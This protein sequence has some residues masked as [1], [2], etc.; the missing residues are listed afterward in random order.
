MKK[1]L[2]SLSK[3]ISYI[4]RHAPSD[5]KLEMDQEGWVSIQDLLQV[6]RKE[7]D[8]W[9]TL[10]I[11]DLVEIINHSPKQRFELINDKIRALYGHSLDEK[12]KKHK[13]EP[14]EILYHGTTPQVAELVSKEGLK[15]MKRQFIHLSINEEIAMEVGYR[16]S[17]T[18]VILSIEARKAYHDG[19]KF[20]VGNDHVWLADFIPSKYL[21]IKK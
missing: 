21:D 13:V 15:P 17:S 9:Q 4:L 1:S 11:S 14:P 12:L 2:A 5:Y 20:Y 10:T 19:V 16:K 6:L 18:P 3:K 7:K 8:E